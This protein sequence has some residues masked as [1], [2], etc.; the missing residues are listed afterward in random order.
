M[1]LY[2]VANRDELEQQ[3][4]AVF[5]HVRMTLQTMWKYWSESRQSCFQMKYL[6][7][8]T[9]CATFFPVLHHSLLLSTF[10]ANE[11]EAIWTTLYLTVQS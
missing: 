9:T 10:P 6:A 2:L 4:A 1:N 7:A 3:K 8:L 5:Q 11:A